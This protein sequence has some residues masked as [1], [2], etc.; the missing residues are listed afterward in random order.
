VIVIVFPYDVSTQ[1]ACLLVNFVSI[2]VEGSTQLAGSL[3]Y[4]DDYSRLFASLHLVWKVQTEN[5]TNGVIFASFSVAT[6]YS[7][8]SLL[9]VVVPPKMT[10]PPSS[11]PSLQSTNFASSSNNHAAVVYNSILAGSCAGVANQTA[12]LGAPQ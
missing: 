9:P 12:I 7:E 5:W 2:L 4:N 1:N 6:A 3:S 8:Y 10:A 11:N